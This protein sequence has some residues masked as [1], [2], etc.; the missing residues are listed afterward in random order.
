MDKIKAFFGSL[1][2]KA[3]AVLAALLIGVFI[4]KRSKKGRR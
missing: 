1:A 4:Y 3:T 2:G